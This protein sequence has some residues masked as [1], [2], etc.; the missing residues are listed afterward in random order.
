LILHEVIF[1]VGPISPTYS[2]RTHPKTAMRGRVKEFDE[3]TD[4]F[5]NCQRFISY[6]A[7]SNQAFFSP[8]QSH[9]AS[10][11]TLNRAAI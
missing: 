3:V 6:Y 2:K 1:I 11:L 7:Q 9:E 5:R 8:S 10:L 4:S